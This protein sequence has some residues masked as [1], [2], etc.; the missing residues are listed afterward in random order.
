MVEEVKS[1]EAQ[2]HETSTSMVEAAPSE[3]NAG[4]DMVLYLLVLIGLI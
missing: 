4:T 2:V 3:L 1:E